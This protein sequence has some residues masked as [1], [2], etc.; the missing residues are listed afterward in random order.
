MWNNKILTELDDGEYTGEIVSITTEQMREGYPRKSFIVRIIGG[1]HDGCFVEKKY[2]LK[3]WKAISFMKKEL[4][5]IDCPI[6]DVDDLMDKKPLIIGTRLIFTAQ[7]NEKGYLSLYFKC[8]AEDEINNN[9]HG[10]GDI[11]HE[12]NYY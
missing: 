1:R 9:G 2:Y 3:N 4:M 5:N 11:S 10:P 7:V 12:N 6:Q 8:C